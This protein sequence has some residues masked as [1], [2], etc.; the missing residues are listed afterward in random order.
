MFL[1]GYSVAMV[2]YL[3]HK[4]NTNVFT[5]DWAFFFLILRLQHQLIKSGYNDS[6]KSKSRNVLE[7][8]LSHLK[9]FLDIVPSSSAD[10]TPRC[11]DVFVK[12]LFTCMS[13]RFV[14][15]KGKPPTL[16][17]CL[18]WYFDYKKGSLGSLYNKIIWFYQL[19]WQCKLATVKRFE[20]WRFER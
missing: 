6:S 18:L 2:T 13:F 1:A 11:V 3:C 16:W 12:D 10:I 8:V 4:N 17:G 9:I 7:T 19:S 5:S 20:S 15:S 14:Q